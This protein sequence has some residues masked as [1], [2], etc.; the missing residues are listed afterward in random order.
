MVCDPAARVFAKA[1]FKALEDG[2][3]ITY[4]FEDAKTAVMC[5][6]RPGRLQGMTTNVPKFELRKPGMATA[7]TSVSPTPIAAGVPVLMI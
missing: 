5:V 3:S 7:M 1:F 2:R 6:T 4:A